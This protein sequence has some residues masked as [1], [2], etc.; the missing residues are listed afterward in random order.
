MKLAINMGNYADRFDDAMSIEIC[1]TA[2]FEAMDWSLMDMVNDDAPF[3]QEN[4]LDLARE[5]RR[6]SDEKQIP[7]TQTHA[8]FTYTAA[9][10]ED[11]AYFEEVI[12]PRMIRSL[13]ISGIL[14]AKVVVIHPIHHSAYRG[15]EEELFQRN[16]EF[17][18][19][20]I[21]YA[22][23]YGV[24]IGVENMWKRDPE[25]G[26]IMADTC[27]D[28]YEFVRYIDALNSPYVTACLDVGHA[29]LP[30]SDYSVADVIRI[31]GHDRLGALHVHDNDYLRDQHLLPYFGKM[32]WA[33]IT[34]ALGEIDYQGEFT[35]E[36]N[37][38]LIFGCDEEFIPVGAKIMKD[39]G[40]YLVSMVEKNRVKAD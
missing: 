5:L 35:Y 25:R 2:G 40:A 26:Y 15:H 27:S 33:E 18:G 1:K 22:K 11:P 17:Y 37:G 30:V 29:V 4:Y 24:K 38:Q 7:I 6:I 8:P 13:E 32:N 21:P 16:M 14:G 20:L 10:W 9:Q 12:M 31:L 36:V 23:E 19:R 28:P 3:N 34:K 39:V